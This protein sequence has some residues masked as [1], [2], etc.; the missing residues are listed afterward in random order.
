MTFPQIQINLKKLKEN[1]EL[2]LKMCRE[3][4]IDSVFLV[5]KVLS[6]D[7]RSVEAIAGLGFS[8]LADSRI[9]N[10]IAFSDIKLPKVLLR[11]PMPSEVQDVIAY[12]D[13]SL[14]SE[15]EVIKLLNQEAEKQNKIHDIILMFDLGDLR[16]GIFFQDDYLKTVEE[17]LD[18]KNIRLLGIGTNLTCYGGIIPTCDNLSEL[19]NI[20]KTIEEKFGLKLTLISGGNSS[21]LHLLPNLPSGI[22]N[23]RIGEALFLGRETAYGKLLLGM[24]TDC[25]VLKAE[26]IEVKTKPSYPIGIMGMDSFGNVPKIKDQGTMRRGILAIGKQDVALE[27]LEPLDNNVEILG[28]SSDHLIVVLKEEHAPGDIL[29]FSVNYPGL[30]RLMTSAYVK[31]VYI[32]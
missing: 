22:N 7:K 9:E 28:G 17:I 20:K 16:E 3:S 29:S 13:V 31:K 15:P 27:D 8:H 24:H 23:L 6:G 14:N 19:I 21:S 1:S 25:F 10:L 26:L 2:L 12:A 18:Y 32:E 30:L 4:G 5:S 11:L